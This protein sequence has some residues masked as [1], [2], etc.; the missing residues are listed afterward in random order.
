[1]STAPTAQQRVVELVATPAPW[2]VPRA[3]TMVA[4]RLAAEE[5]VGA[6]DQAAYDY[7]TEGNKL[8]HIF[9]AKHGFA[10]LVQQFGS[11]EAAVQAMLDAL[12]GVTPAS[13]TF[14]EAINVGGQT[15]VVRGAVVNGVTK[16]GTAFTP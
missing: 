4:L 8:D 9:A 6:A 13:G 16:I 3:S 14:E 12:K 11:R 15:V 7:A 2:M 1:M 10:G 5:T